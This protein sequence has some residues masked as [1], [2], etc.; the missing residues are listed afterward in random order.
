MILVI[1]HKK[2]KFKSKKYAEYVMI[3][4]GQSQI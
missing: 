4:I 3:P 2:I 1:E